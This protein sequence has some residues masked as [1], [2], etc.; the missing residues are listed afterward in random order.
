MPD[1]LI[2]RKDRTV[3]YPVRTGDGSN[4]VWAREGQA[5]A[6]DDPLLDTTDPAR[7]HDNL[8]EKYHLK[9]VSERHKL[10]PPE[11]G[12]TIRMAPTLRVMAPLYAA[13]DYQH[14]DGVPGAVPGRRPAPARDREPERVAEGAT[15]TDNG[16]GKGRRKAPPK[17]DEPAAA[18]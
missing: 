15:A 4:A 2:V 9:R 12:E 5:V 11:E 6:A 10:R 16:A 8:V 14:P 18:E 1:F 7:V 13:L 3:F 17:L